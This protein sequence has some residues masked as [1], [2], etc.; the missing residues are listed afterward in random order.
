MTNSYFFGEYNPTSIIYEGDMTLTND[1]M[2]RDIKGTITN[3][4]DYR[5][6]LKL[7]GKEEANDK[8]LLK[9]LTGDLLGEFIL[10]AGDYSGEVYIN[11]I[12]GN[13]LHGA[14]LRELA[15]E[16]KEI[17]KL[18]FS[19]VNLIPVGDEIKKVNKNLS[20]RGLSTVTFEDWTIKLV[21]NKKHKKI[22]EEMNT[23]K[24]FANTHYGEI[25]YKN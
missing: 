17:D 14:I 18:T 9:L 5:H 4:F 13:Y 22:Y 16:D 8:S 12:K 11:R 7:V 21:K 15:Y 25:T 10:N 24:G 1:E 3:S 20:Y 19:I 6:Q 23:Y 2:N